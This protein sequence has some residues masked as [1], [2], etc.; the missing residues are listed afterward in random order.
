MNLLAVFVGGLIGGGL[1]LGIDALLPHGSADLPVSTLIINVT[2]SFVLGLLVGRVWPAAPGWLRAGLG[3]GV[4]GSFTTFSA[5]MVSLFTLVSTAPL[6]ALAYLL[7][8]LIAGLG[9]AAAGLGLGRRPP[10]ITVDE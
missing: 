7:A 10:R 3:T 8:S 4:L 9:A 2:G 6:T 1:R 5:V